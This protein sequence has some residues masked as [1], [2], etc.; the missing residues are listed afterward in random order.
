MAT[1]F[2]P[3]PHR[4]WCLHQHVCSSFCCQV[5]GG[6]MVTTI[7]PFARP[8]STYAIA[9]SVSSNGNVRSSSERSV[10]RADDADRQATRS[11]HGQRLREVVATKG[12]EHDVVVG[13]RLGE[14]YLRIVDDFVC[15]EAAHLLLVVAVRSCGDVC[16][17]VLGELDDCRAQSARASVNEDLLPRLDLCEVD[18]RLPR[19]K[20]YQRD[21]RRLF[22]RERVR[23]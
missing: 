17:Q 8:C 4:R 16:A 12:V 11:E 9:S 1:A 13:E 19:G 14:V 2:W 10:R 15:A 18:Q 5:P 23:L 21:R 20:R 7:L 3:G 6:G 22:H